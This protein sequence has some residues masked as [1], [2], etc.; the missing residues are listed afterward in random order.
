MGQRAG[1]SPEAVRGDPAMSEALAAKRLD[2]RFQPRPY[3]FGRGV[4]PPTVIRPV[5]RRPPGA[6]VQP[7]IPVRSG[8]TEQPL[9]L[10][11]NER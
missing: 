8:V 11:A 5:P 4:I 7:G 1:M 3:D 10:P 6:G 2:G 9:L